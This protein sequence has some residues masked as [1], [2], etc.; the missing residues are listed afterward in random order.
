MRIVVDTNIVFSAIVNSNSRIAQI[1]LRPKTKLN[2]YAT[3]Q[4][5]DEVQ[6]HKQKIQAISN[7]SAADLEKAISLICSRIR[8]IDVRLI[9]PS[10]FAKAEQLTADVDI[11][12]T[13]FVALTEHA[14]AKLWSGDNRLI[15]GLQKKKWNKFVTTSDLF[16]YVSGGEKP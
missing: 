3:H 10:V 16:S 6:E 7:Y 4:L 1:L 5:F 14:K 13:E 9:P 11:D 2:F 8:F 15:A 12:D